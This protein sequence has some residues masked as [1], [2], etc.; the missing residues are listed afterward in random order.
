MDETGDR[1]GAKVAAEL[2]RLGREGENIG[3]RNMPDVPTDSAAPNRDSMEIW[4]RRI[5]RTLGWAAAAFLLFQL[6]RIYGQ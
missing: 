5:G 6:M 3:G 4:G 2:E 1:R